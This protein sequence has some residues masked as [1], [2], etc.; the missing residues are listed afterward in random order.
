MIFIV[1]ERVLM[2]WVHDG[3]GIMLVD[4]KNAFNSVNRGLECSTGSL[5][6]GSGCS[7]IRCKL[8]LLSP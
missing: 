8:H 2:N 6:P 5:R 7:I 3:F 4:A 1:F